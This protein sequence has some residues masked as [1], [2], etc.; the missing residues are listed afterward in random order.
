MNE[1]WGI[2]DQAGE[3]LK[4]DSIGDELGRKEERRDTPEQ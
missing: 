1:G 2:R 3:S 4:E